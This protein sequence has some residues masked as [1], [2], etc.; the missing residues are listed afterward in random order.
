MNF[1]STKQYDLAP[2]AYLVIGSK[3][4]ALYN[5]K[6]W[7][8]YSINKIALKVVLGKIQN[9]LFWQQL[10]EL[11]LA[12][13]LNKKSRL[14]PIVLCR[15]NNDDPSDNSL[16]FIWFEIMGTGCNQK[17]IHCY[18]NSLQPKTNNII[19]DKRIKPNR[20]H[21]LLSFNEWCRLI[22]EGSQLGCK[23]CQFI[24]GEPF[25]YKGS[26]GQTVLDLAEYAVIEGYDF[27]EIFTNGTLIKDSHIQKIQALKLNIAI[28]IYSDDKTIHD[29][30]TGI[31]GSFQRTFNVLKKLKKANIP[32]RVAVILMKQNENTIEKTLDLFNSMGFSSVG[33]D[34]IRPQGKG[35][36]LT[37]IPS[38]SNQI[39]YG[40]KVRPDFIA[41]PTFIKRSLIGNNCLN[42]KLAITNNGEVLPCI[43]FRNV[44]LGNV[45]FSQ[46][47]SL[48]IENPLLQK[49]WNITKDDVQVCHDCEYRYVCHDCRFLSQIHYKTRSL[50]FNAP[51]PHCTYN[52][53]TGEWAKGIWKLNKKNKLFYDR[54]LENRVHSFINI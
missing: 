5:T 41:D 42:G 46:P 35:A 49:L 8:V 7:K 28:S 3:R 24:G 47:L 48:S 16:Y 27:V 37:L 45:N 11:E 30:I 1:Q 15:H 34:L 14:T 10:H 2:S 6:D 50:C 25:L 21:R 33:T 32:T 29:S 22:R 18:I 13:E 31:S 23:R 20:M 19:I 54:S 44:K 26:D 12:K 17:C 36:D 52:P 43:F 53:Y 39:R 51:N 40:L 4:A 9:N 38:I